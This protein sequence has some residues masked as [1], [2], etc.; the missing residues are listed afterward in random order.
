MYYKKMEELRQLTAGRKAVVDASLE[1]YTSTDM[2]DPELD[3]YDSYMCNIRRDIPRR[4][5]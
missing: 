1:S 2:Y 4:H 3:W 5:I